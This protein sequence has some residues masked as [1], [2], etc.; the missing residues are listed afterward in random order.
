MPTSFKNFV[1]ID[2]YSTLLTL[3]SSPF[4]VCNV[5]H[6][7]PLQS[8]HFFRLYIFNVNMKAFLK[9]RMRLSLYIEISYWDFWFGKSLSINLNILVATPHLRFS[10]SSRF[11]F[12]TL[13]LTC[14][15][16]LSLFPCFPLALSPSHPSIC[17]FLLR[18]RKLRWISTSMVL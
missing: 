16:Y 14:F 17:L 6:P 5:T 2:I 3:T 13:S 4:N 11:S 9:S 1:Y 18:H 12:Y 7:L 15:L 10:F 8:C